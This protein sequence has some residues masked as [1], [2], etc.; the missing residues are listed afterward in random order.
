MTSTTMHDKVEH[1]STMVPSASPVGQSTSFMEALPLASSTLPREI[2][3]FGFKKANI[4]QK[5]R[6]MIYE[7]LIP[8]ARIVA[9]VDKE[10]NSEL[11]EDV[12]KT[13]T[14]AKF[15]MPL[16]CY[17]PVFNYSVLPQPISWSDFTCASYKSA[18]RLA[19]TLT[20]EAIPSSL[21]QIPAD[22]STSTTAK[23]SSSSK[24]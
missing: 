12:Y 5:I 24:V 15:P 22:R 6:T 1:I 21:Y 2:I 10:W 19:N 4:K 14:I 7:H 23:T 16:V 9:I 3:E 18:P 17:S 13:N 8:P 11:Q 20:Q